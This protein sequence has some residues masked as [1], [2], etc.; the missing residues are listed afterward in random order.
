[1]HTYHPRHLRAK[2]RVSAEAMAKALHIS[3]D[4]LRKLEDSPIDGWAVGRVQEYVEACGHRLELVAVSASGAV[5]NP[6]L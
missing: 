2:A 6:L 3:V 1:M 5:R 4:T